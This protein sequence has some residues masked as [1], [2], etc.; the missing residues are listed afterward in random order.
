MIRE[1]KGLRRLVDVDVILPFHRVDRFLFEAIDSVRN[2]VGVRT[3]I[4]GVDDIVG[5]S[6]TFVGQTSLFDELVMT[7]GGEGYGAALTVATESVEA[8]FVAL[9]N[10]DDLIHPT[11]LVRQVMKL[12]R[13]DVCVTGVER[14]SR[15]GRT[16]RS[17]VGQ[18]DWNRF[19]PRYLLLGPYAAD[20]SWCA[21]TEWWRQTFRPDALPMLDWR[22]AM[23][24]LDRA[25]VA[26]ISDRLY[27]YR[28]HPNQVSRALIEPQHLS[29]IYASWK[30]LAE[31]LGLS[32]LPQEEAL[33]IAMPWQ[34]S[35]IRKLDTKRMLLWAGRFLE[36]FSNDHARY[37]ARRLLQRRFFL[38][39]TLSHLP[40]GER[41]L[42]ISRSG[43]QS[44]SVLSDGLSSLLFQHR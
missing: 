11:R 38:L 19:D 15:S 7:G 39:A 26:V 17:V 3:R 34:G 40:L 32:P 21:R 22:L 43:E 36:T 8:E 12:Q 23:N 18:P 2:Q 13:A 33:A 30:S 9:M 14:I 27:S 29:V 6:G 16:L 10:S 35:A 44:L 31:R 20:A 41:T 5:R 24:S 4:I 1:A 37:D 42:L 28:K 25:S